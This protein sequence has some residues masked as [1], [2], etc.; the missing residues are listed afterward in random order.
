MFLPLGTIEIETL[1]GRKLWFRARYL[2]VGAILKDGTE[3]SGPF[4]TIDDNIFMLVSGAGNSPE[5]A[6]VE[7]IQIDEPA[8]PVVIDT[9]EVVLRPVR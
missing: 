3:F 2:G 6:F 9:A 5:S 1:A 8:R 4:F 7:F